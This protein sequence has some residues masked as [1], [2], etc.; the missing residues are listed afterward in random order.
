MVGCLPGVCT[1]LHQAVLRNDLC[2]AALLAAAKSLDTLCGY[3]RRVDPFK[4]HAG[5]AF[6]LLRGQEFRL[7][8]ACTF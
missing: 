6:L 4:E 5:T 1:D 7:T 2:G 8:N 3:V